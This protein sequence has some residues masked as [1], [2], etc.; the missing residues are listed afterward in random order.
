MRPITA[1]AAASEKR[2][3]RQQQKDKFMDFCPPAWLACLVTG[4]H[5]EEGLRL[6]DRASELRYHN[7]GSDR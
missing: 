5:E 4:T 1:G 7:R 3:K 2:L 6:Q